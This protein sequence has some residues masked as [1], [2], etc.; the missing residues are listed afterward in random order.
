LKE[1]RQVIGNAA[2]IASTTTQRPINTEKRNEQETKM[3]PNPQQLLVIKAVFPE[4]IRLLL[5]GWKYKIH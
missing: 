3:E 5:I 4:G 2:A 1:Y